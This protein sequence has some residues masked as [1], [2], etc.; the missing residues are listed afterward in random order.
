[1]PASPLPRGAVPRS[2]GFEDTVGGDGGWRGGMSGTDTHWAGISFLEDARRSLRCDL[3]SH[4][5]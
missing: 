2:G 3:G 4:G 1:M 5:A